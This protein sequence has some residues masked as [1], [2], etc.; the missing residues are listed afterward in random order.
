[1]VIKVATLVKSQESYLKQHSLPPLII[2]Q[3][4]ELVRTKTIWITDP[5]LQKSNSQHLS[6][7]EL[8]PTKDKIDLQPK[9]I[10]P[11]KKSLFQ[12]LVDAFNK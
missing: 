11:K 9:T 10:K 5:P 3:P 2:P 1:M 8:Y 4:P 7:H 12:K 6:L